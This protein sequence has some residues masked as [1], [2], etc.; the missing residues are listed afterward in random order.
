MYHECIAEGNKLLVHSMLLYLPVRYRTIHIHLKKASRQYQ[1]TQTALIGLDRPSLSSRWVI[2]SA[3]LDFKPIRLFIAYNRSVPEL[4]R[5][6]SLYEFQSCFSLRALGLRTLDCDLWASNFGLWS[7]VVCKYRLIRTEPT[8]FCSA[9]RF[10]S[11]AKK[12]KQC[13]TRYKV[14]RLLQSGGNE[15]KNMCPPHW[16]VFVCQ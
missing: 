13:T 5:W 12:P 16:F 7:I 4:N 10:D 11:S 6:A 9:H 2:N 3:R 15:A 8:L 14:V 1:A